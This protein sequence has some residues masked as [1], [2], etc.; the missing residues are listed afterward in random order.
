MALKN[1][2]P[3]KSTQKKKVKKTYFFKNEKVRFV[4]GVIVLLV[5]VYFLIAFISFL[6]S[7]AADQSKLDLPWSELVFNREIKV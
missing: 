7:G 4:T 3:S 2:K 5:A 6:F 1:S